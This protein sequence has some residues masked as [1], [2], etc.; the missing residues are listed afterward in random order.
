MLNFISNMGIY[1][2]NRQC[3]KKIPNNDIIRCLGSKRETGVGHDP[4]SVYIEDNE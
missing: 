1:Q 3:A 4:E 2:Y